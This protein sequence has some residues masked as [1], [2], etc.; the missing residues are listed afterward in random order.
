VVLAKLLLGSIYLHGEPGDSPKM[1]IPQNDPKLVI[2]ND[3]QREKPNGLLYQS[4]R[5]F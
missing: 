4:F 2:T 5:L 3:I 1:L